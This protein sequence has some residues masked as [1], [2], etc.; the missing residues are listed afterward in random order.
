MPELIPL[1]ERIA[2]AAHPDMIVPEH[3]FGGE[4]GVC[5]AI[6]VRD[7]WLLSGITDAKMKEL[8]AARKRQGMEPLFE[9]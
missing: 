5:R 6:S 7:F 9:E 2:K 8:D 3:D 4:I 1:T